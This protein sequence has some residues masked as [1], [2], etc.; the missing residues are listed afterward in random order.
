MDLQ[1]ERTQPFV[2][3]GALE[4]TNVTPIFMLSEL[5]SSFIFVNRF[6]QEPGL[7][8]VIFF[9]W[10]ILPRRHRS[11]KLASDVQKQGDWTLFLPS[12]GDLTRIDRR[13]R[14]DIRLITR[15]ILK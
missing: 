11:I 4:E 14:V 15:S 9:A 7:H 3:R 5:Q 1:G 10:T 13:Q 8:G 12:A 6:D 2:F